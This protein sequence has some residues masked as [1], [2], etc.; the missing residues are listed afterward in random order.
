MTPNDTPSDRGTVAESPARVS[1]ALDEAE[2]RA[3]LARQRLCVVSMVDGDEPYAV[4]VYYGF[5][6]STLFLGVAEG[7]KT[8]ALDANPSVYIVV[9]EVGPGDAW[10]SVTV[11][12]RARSLV[13]GPERQ[14]AVEVL[15][16]HNRRVRAREGVPAATPRRRSGGRVLRV[17]GVRL[18]GRASG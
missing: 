18:S 2:C 17:D 15:M 12:G 8:R 9:T 4:P 5:D 13:D 10:R 11:A 16:A 7:R 14:E 3:I 6:G 1:A